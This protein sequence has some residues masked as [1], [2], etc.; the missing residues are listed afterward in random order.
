[1][2]SK[3][4]E[5]AEGAQLEIVEL[6][7]LVHDIAD[8]KFHGGDDTAGPREARKLRDYF[9]MSSI[10]LKSSSNHR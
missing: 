9:K 1:M 3:A 6:G 5:A 7:A 4:I 10:R 8:W 2:L